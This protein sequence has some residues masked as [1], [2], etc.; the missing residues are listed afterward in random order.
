MIRE[1]IAK[2]VEGHDLV[3]EEME[4]VM[5]EIMSG[6]ATPA[7]IGAFITAL[8]LKGET[9]E[10]ITGAAIIMRRKA[11]RV[12]VPG[13]EAD[14]EHT[15]DQSKRAPLVDTC[16]TGGDRTGTF[17]ISTAT[18]F[19]VAG[20]GLK[21]AKHGNRSVSSKC[22]SADV[23][24]ELGVNIEMPPEN[25]GR[26]I[27]EIGIG[28]LYAPLFHNAMKY[29]IGPRREIGIRTIFNILGPLTNPAGASV[30]ILGVY[31]GSL[32]EIMARVLNN[33]GVKAAYVA[34]GLDAL[35]EISITGQTRITELRNS[36]IR[37]F[38]VKPEDFGF[39]TAALNEIRGGDVREN[40]DII[41]NVMKGEKSA[42]RD[43]VLLNSAFCLHA[44][45][46]VQDIQG[47]IKMA[48][49]SIDQGKAIKKLELLREYTNRTKK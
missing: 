39:K 47:G 42:R 7:Q 10:E 43:V 37:T 30:Q 15:D 45:G 41:L 11:L 38:N 36:Q 16:G 35:D 3:Q 48:E 26:C 24:R 2:V 19:V 12:R 34:H 1:A 33:L 31:D 49:E 14:S 17:N 23:L 27:S 44:G 29:A 5:D 46:M 8:R 4:Q 13:Y 32:T 20:A 9:V 22:G 6:E 25:V 28:F 21:V 18:A 40:A